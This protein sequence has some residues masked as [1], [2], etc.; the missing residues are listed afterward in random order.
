MGAFGP[1][2]TILLFFPLQVN[3]H[4]IFYLA[5]I[6]VPVRLFQGIFWSA[7]KSYAADFVP[8]YFRASGVGWYSTIVGL[9]GLIASLIA[10]QLQHLP[11]YSG[12]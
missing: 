6:G 10:G 7:G 1:L 5:I 4:Y 2:L 8:V 3:I 11:D 9:S 12:F